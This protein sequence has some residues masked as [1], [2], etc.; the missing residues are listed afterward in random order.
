M[1]QGNWAEWGAR[2]KIGLAREGAWSQLNWVRAICVG[3]EP[4]SDG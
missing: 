4:G 3:V 2:L 1:R